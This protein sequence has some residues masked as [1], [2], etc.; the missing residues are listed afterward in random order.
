[1]IHILN[2]WKL[3]LC[4]NIVWNLLMEILNYTFVGRNQMDMMSKEYVL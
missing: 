3:V 2:N 4:D 1:M